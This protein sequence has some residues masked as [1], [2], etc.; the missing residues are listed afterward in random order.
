MERIIRNPSPG[1]MVW[2]MYSNGGGA[3]SACWTMLTVTAV[4]TVLM[5]R[6]VTRVNRERMGFFLCP[7]TKDFLAGSKPLAAPPLTR[8]TRVP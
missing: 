3:T 6:R 1:T 4:A 2:L 8:P 5:N 7:S